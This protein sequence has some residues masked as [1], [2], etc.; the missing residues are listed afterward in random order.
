MREGVELNIKSAPSSRDPGLESLLIGSG[1]LDSVDVG[2]VLFDKDGAVLDCNRAATDLLG[3][4]RRQLLAPRLG[5]RLRLVGED[6]RRVAKEE[7]PTALTLRTGR[8]CKHLIL[9]IDKPSAGRRW[10]SC[11]TWP[12]TLD[13]ETVGV[14]EVFDDH[15]E[16]RQ[17]QHFLRL[18]T[19][20][21]H[22][23]LFS[24][25]EERTLREVC[26]ALIS[27]GSLGL[28][29][30]AMDAGE[31]DP[32]ARIVCVSGATDFP[33]GAMLADT[34]GDGAN[35]NPVAV[36]LRTGDVQVVDDLRGDA[37]FAPWRLAAERCHFNACV[38]IPLRFNDSRYALVA[39]ADQRNA[40]DGESVKALEEMARQVEVGMEHARSVRQ[41]GAALEGTLGALSQM[42]EMRDPYT[43]GHQSQVGRLSGAIAQKLQLDPS[44]VGLVQQGAEVHDIGKIVIPAEILTLPRR[45][46]DLEMEMVKRH[47]AVGSQILSKASLPA[48]IADVALQH[49]ERLNGSGYPDG[50]EDAAIV[51]PARIVA[52]ADVVEA[53]TQHRPYRPGLGLDRA[54]HEVIS[55]QGVLYDAEVVRACVAVFEEGFTFTSPREPT[56]FDSRLD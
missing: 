12:L 24:D 10:M 29:A 46:S 40:F 32:G 35:S 2:I 45:L 27:H 34:T 44:Q 25:D 4:S 9:G 37:R 42:T 30:I 18:L 1:F 26:D 3:M 50:L 41:L 20:V 7:T 49:H 13:G 53:M 15:T 51:F 14:V 52:V 6:G 55:H 48:T 36:A 23:V 21:M 17:R 47:S 54:L 11:D 8:P 22:V 38:V 56:L 16:Q 33:L 39:F 5:A 28:V 31:P 43:A 19:D